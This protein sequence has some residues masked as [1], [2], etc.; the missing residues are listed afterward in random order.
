MEEKKITV[1]DE[2]LRQAAG[3]GMDEFCKCLPTA[4]WK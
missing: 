1:S 3:E 4:I 2:A